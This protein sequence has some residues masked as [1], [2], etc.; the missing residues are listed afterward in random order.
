MATFSDTIYMKVLGKT[1]IESFARRHPHARRPLS[2]WLAIVS[3]SKWG[4]YADVKDTF[5]TADKVGDY[6]VFNI[7]GK[8]YRLIAI[9]VIAKDKVFIDKILT[10]EK[11]NK[12]E[13]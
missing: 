11:Y 13:P 2:E 8:K 7:A 3:K 5:N 6:F 9:V 10:H 1:K 4:N 12:W